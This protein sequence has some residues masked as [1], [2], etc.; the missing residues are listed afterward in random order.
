MDLEELRAFLMVAE[1]GSFLAAE[2]RLGMPRATLRRRVEAL[3][4]RAG[5][6]LL[7]RTRQGVSLTVAGASLA[8]RGR[9]MAQEAAALVASVR[10]LGREPA[11]LLRVQL[12]PGMPP[13]ILTQL[14]AAVRASY[15]KLSVRVRLRD[16][17]M[18]GLLDDVDIAIHSGEETPPGPWISHEVLRVREWMLASRAYLD[19]RGT[20]ATVEDLAGHE[21]FAWEA[22]GGDPRAWPLVL[23]GT[24]PVNP[25]LVATDIHFLRQCAVSGLG[26]ALIPDGGFEDPAEVA[27]QM[28]PVLPNVVGRERVFRMVVPKALADMPKIRAVLQH[29]QGFLDEIT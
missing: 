7:H 10:E 14:F 3:E 15:S 26:I 21:L 16:D 19:A 29:V 4:A 18:G 27:A 22:P 28:V 13:Q 20:P 9:L 1:T 2:Q 8:D 6:S 24:F 25:S 23:G 12:P 11:G 17:P 5:V